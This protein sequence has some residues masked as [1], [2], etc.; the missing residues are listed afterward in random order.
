MSKV[1]REI[2]IISYYIKSSIGVHL[3]VDEMRE[4]RLRQI[5]HVFRREKSEAVRLIKERAINRIYVEGK[6]RREILKIGW[7]VIESN[8]RKSSINEE[9]SGYRVS[10]SLGRE[11][12][13]QSS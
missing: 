7:D 12:L 11:W 9:D 5:G 10:G 8:M 2:K 4:N 13:T 1:T 6:R 3:I